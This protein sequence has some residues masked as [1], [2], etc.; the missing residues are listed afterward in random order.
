MRVVPLFITL[1]CIG[2]L[3]PA[4]SAAQGEKEP[5]Q[6]ALDM[7]L[8]QQDLDSGFAQLDQAFN[9]DPE[10]SPEEVYYLGRAV[11]A[12][13]LE[14]YTLYMRNPALIEY[15][16]LICSALVL[17]SA[18]PA[19][20]N[21]YH[22]LLLDTQEINAFA[23]SGGHIFISLG[24]VEAADSEDTLAAVIAHEIAHIQLR[25]GLALMQNMRLTQDLSAAG[26]RAGDIAARGTPQQAQSNLFAGQVREMVNVM[27]VQGYSQ[28]QEFEADSLAMD[29]LVLT[30]YEPASLI[31]ILQTLETVQEGHP[32]GFAK[33]HPAPALRI[34]KAKQTLHQYVPDTRSFRIPRYYRMRGQY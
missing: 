1:C 5:V 26:A 13:I 30:G 14:Q 9:Q 8:L 31:E 22:V 17:N 15:L 34:A 20:F 10:L 28:A 18:E 27:V 4:Y 2:L 32:G 16:N 25:H 24:L 21:G 7:G 33:T 23:T 12:N 19:I 6:P 11:A 3:F 29:L